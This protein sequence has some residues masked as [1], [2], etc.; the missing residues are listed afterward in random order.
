M[1]ESEAR[2]LVA[3]NFLLWIV[4]VLQSVVLAAMVR[5]LRSVTGRAVMGW[6][7]RGAAAGGGGRNVGETPPGGRDTRSGEDRTLLLCISGEC[8]VGRRL[9][10]DADLLARTEG[11][12]LLLAR[13]PEAPAMQESPLLTRGGRQAERKSRGRTPP[14]AAPYAMIINADGQVAAQGQ[15]GSRRDLVNL[16]ARAAPEFALDP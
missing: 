13:D 5:N 10:P 8:Q 4:V 3:S 14:P 16:F 12:R 6:A 7:G 15:A 11:V 9:I 1:T 2:M